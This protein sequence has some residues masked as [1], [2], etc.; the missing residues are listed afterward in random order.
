MSDERFDQDLRAVLD[1][2]APRAVPDDLRRRVAAIPTNRPVVGAP[3]APMWR[4]PV[5]L[6]IGMLAAAAIVVAVGV[7]RLGPSQ[8]QG[9]GGTPSATAPSALAPITSAPGTTPPSSTAPSSSA[10][11][12]ASASSSAP[13]AVAAC[14]GSDLRG[15]ILDWQGAAGSR[16]ADVEI[17][18]DS[19][20]SCTVRGTPGLQLID[21]RG[22]VLIDSA[23][24]GA[25]GR[26]HVGSSDPSF[27][28]APG[29]NLHTQVLASNYCGPTPTLPVS[30]SFTLP[31]GGGSFL[32]APAAGVSSAEAIPPC[33]GSTGTQLTMNGWRR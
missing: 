1:E 12:A 20:R 32:A 6:G 9:V 10:S 29:G 3:I 22:R 7:S 4:R 2:D 8:S 26:P 18:N 23:S 15:R 27:E 5:P 14:K 16:I 19:G 31:S 25:S 24:E 13:V 33:M 17:T 28:L 21:A 11:P 30:I